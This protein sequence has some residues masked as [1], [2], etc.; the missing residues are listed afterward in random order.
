M[1]G[2]WRNYSDEQWM[3]LRLAVDTEVRP[4]SR[5]RY[6]TA[7]VALATPLAGLAVYLTP[8]QSLIPRL[9][10]ENDMKLQAIQGAAAAALCAGSALA[11]SSAVVAW[12][13]IGEGQANVP[14]GLRTPVQISAGLYHTL[15]IDSTGRAFAWGWNSAGQ[16]DVPQIPGSVRQVSAG[17]QHSVALSQAGRVYCWGVNTH[18]QCDVPAELPMVRSI[19][20]GDEFTLAVTADGLVHAWGRNNQG[21]TTLPKQLANVVEVGGGNSHALARRADGTVVAW[22]NDGFGASSVPADLSGVVQVVAGAW[23]SIALKSDRTVVC[24]GRNQYG[25]LNVPTGLGN[26]VA[27]SGE[28]SNVTMVLLEDGSVRVW[29]QWNEIFTNPT[30]PSAITRW[31]TISCGGYHAIGIPEAETCVGDLNA[32]GVIDG[33]DLSEVLSNWGACP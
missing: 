3:R 29:G 21:Q 10:K 18:G 5:I 22:G 12:G 4:C 2:D 25:Q 27:I 11:Q 15:A 17:W 20:S 33:G 19:G 26:V 14:A 6:A 16:S 28:H 32:D 8:E 24:W 23:H 13:R 9:S 30:P 1:R 31:R 7:L